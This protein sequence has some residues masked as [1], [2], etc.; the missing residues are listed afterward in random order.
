MNALGSRRMIFRERAIEAARLA[1]LALAV[2][3]LGGMAEAAEVRGRDLGSHGELEFEWDG[4]ADYRMRRDGDR[5]L[6]DFDRAI[7]EGAAGAF[8]AVGRYI[9]QGRIIGDGSTFLMIVDPAIVLTDR[10]SGNAVVFEL[11]NFAEE[12]QA[13]QPAPSDSAPTVAAVHAGP[14][15]LSAPVLDL[16]AEP[17][18]RPAVA[19]RP[20]IRVRGGEHPGYSRIVFDWPDTVDYRVEHSG[21]SVRVAFDAPADADF[22]RAAPAGLSRVDGLAQSARAGDLVVAVAVPPDSRLRHFRSGPKVVLD[23][24]DGEAAPAPDP[25]ATRDPT[26][27]PPPAPQQAERPDPVPPADRDPDARTQHAASGSGPETPDPSLEPDPDAA[28]QVAEL[29]QSLKP[30]S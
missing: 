25:V 12:P 19:S 21:G 13:A 14:P 16:S 9:E 26:P 10:R 27:D 18:S 29:L 11:R 22:A 2:A 6:V 28:P 8:R 15:A 4:P 30:Q 5:I 3:L 23:I 20:T 24:L 17:E 1:A 7:G